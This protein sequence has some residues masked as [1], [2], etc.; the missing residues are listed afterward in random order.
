MA[1]IQ[2]PTLSGLEK[3][4][5]QRNPSNGSWKSEQC[6]LKSL[7]VV[8]SRVMDHICSTLWLMNMESR[9]ASNSG[10]A[11]QCT[12]AAQLSPRSDLKTWENLLVSCALRT[13]GGENKDR[14]DAGTARAH[15]SIN[16]AQ[17]GSP[18]PV[19]TA[20]QVEA[21]EALE[22][23]KPVYCPPGRRSPCFL[24][25]VATLSLTLI[26]L[27]SQSLSSFHGEHRGNSHLPHIRLAKLTFKE[28]FF[29]MWILNK[30]NFI[31]RTQRQLVE[32]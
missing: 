6:V 3:L 4:L 30:E 19:H 29:L 21:C 1:I 26:W 15:E 28:G 17:Q 13:T 31:S 25:P 9:Y 18:R 5:G 24:I 8:S 10:A 2:C 20:Y 14:G 12:L 7:H 32:Y 11:T 27:S 22:L 16:L 23:G